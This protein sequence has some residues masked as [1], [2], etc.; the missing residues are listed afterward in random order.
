VIAGRRCWCA[1]SGGSSGHVGG[2]G[3]VGGGV[4]SHCGG[5]V[6][7][8]GCMV[9][10]TRVLSGGQSLS[11]LLFLFPLAGIVSIGCRAGVGKTDWHR[12]RCSSRIVPSLCD[13]VM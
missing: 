2:G 6:V 9:T 5:G 7:G 3:G 4:D 13:A 12:S 1:G 8:C 11:S 10:G